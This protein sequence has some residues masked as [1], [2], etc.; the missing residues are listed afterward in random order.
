[1]ITALRADEMFQALQGPLQLY[2]VGGRDGASRLVCQAGEYIPPRSLG[3]LMNLVTPPRV[4]VL[5]SEELGFL[6]EVEP[7]ARR[8]LIGRMLAAELG[9][10]IVCGDTPLLND[11]QA[12][13]DSCHAPL[14]HTATSPSEV[15]DCLSDYQ[16]SLDASSTLLHGVFL[17]VYGLGVML[18][19]D[20][21]TGKSELALE[22]ISRGHRLIADDAPRLTRVAP[23]V[24][25]GTCPDSL[26]NFLE[27]RGL[28][29]LNVRRMFGDSAIKRNKRLR[30]I[31][32]LVRLE[33]AALAPEVR[34]HGARKNRH[35]LDV[36]IPEIT[37][38]IAPG[39]NLA[40]LVECA[41]RDHILRLGGYNADHD[42]MERLQAE[43]S[44]RP[45]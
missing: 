41:V 23:Q 37:L 25:E 29:I 17:E 18:T 12:C 31:V 32:H 4:Q 6:A 15:L 44:G 7:I 3:G 27:V 35:I 24:I 20:S 19:G 39:R 16:H 28:G 21:S 43:M 40:V 14:W 11:L 10:T 42:L 38:P 2:W 22:L 36:P 26:R 1:M 45:S 9:A 30:L 34:L 5:G 8:A 13:A 33:D